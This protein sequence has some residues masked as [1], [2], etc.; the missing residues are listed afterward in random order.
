MSTIN[1]YLESF[2]SERS[3]HSR[4]NTLKNM[5]ESIPHQKFCFYHL[6]TRGRAWIKLGDAWYVS[7]VSIIFDCSMLLYYL[8]WMFMVFNIHFYIIFGTNLITGGPTQIAVFFCLF[9]C[10]A[11]K[12]YQTES[13]RNETF[14]R[15]IFGTNAIQETWSRSQEANEE[16]TRQGGAP[17]PCGPLVAPLTDFLRLYISTYPENI[18]EHRKTIFPPS[19]RSVP[20]RSHLGAFSDAPPEGESV[21]EG[22]YINTIASPM[23]CE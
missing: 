8:F 9:Q 16:V 18:Q 13:E 20:V 11:K 12:E 4:E 6:P 14:G 7:N 15:V 1:F 3:C 23:I 5:L 22:F 17:H 10:F 2:S 19:Q 21:T